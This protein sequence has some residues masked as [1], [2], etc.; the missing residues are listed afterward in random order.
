M[1]VNPLSSSMKM[2]ENTVE[3][4]QSWFRKEDA[5]DVVSVGSAGNDNT[6]QVKIL[7]LEMVLCPGVQDFN[8]GHVNDTVIVNDIRNFVTENGGETVENHSFYHHR[9]N[10]EDGDRAVHT[11]RMD[12]WSAAIT[13]VTSWTKDDGSNIC[14]DTIIKNGM[15]FTVK[16]QS[17]TVLG[18]M[19]FWEL[20]EFMDSLGFSEEEL[21]ICIWY[22]TYGL[23]LDPMVCS[24]QPAT[25]VKTLC[26]DGTSD[27]SKCPPTDPPASS[28][29]RP[30]FWTAGSLTLLWMN[31]HNGVV[32]LM[33]TM[34]VSCFGFVI[35]L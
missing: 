33:M 9:V 10:G 22:L 29:S 8:V 21:E 30:T 35:M 12:Q 4:L 11:E 31:S 2:V 32:G 28:S 27:L 13:N 1:T 20:N 25:G 16:N 17:L 3:V 19:S 34:C 24:M 7:G 14:L 23:A 6:I 18:T 26:K 5:G 15:D